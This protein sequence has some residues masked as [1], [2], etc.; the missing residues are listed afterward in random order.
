MP[1][2]RRGR[3]RFAR[4]ELLDYMRRNNVR[5]S[6]ELE[7]KRIDGDPITFDY[8]REFGGWAAAVEEAFGKPALPTKVDAMYVL[9]AVPFFNAWTTRSYLAARRASPDVLPSI[10]F[11]LK[12]FRTFKRF[13]ALA[14]CM[15]L[16]CVA[17]GYDRLSRKL[18]R[19][20]TVD[21]CRADGLLLDFALEFFGGKKGLDDFVDGIDG[22][23]V[24]RRTR[25]KNE[26]S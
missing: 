22:E 2:R 9:R 4:D 17:D 16:K 11:V 1:R 6:R 13:V 18:G 25:R 26:E 23:K 24:P 12:E 15:S 14:R 19:R 20:P 8:R 21:E 10:N 3:R 7:R 5:S